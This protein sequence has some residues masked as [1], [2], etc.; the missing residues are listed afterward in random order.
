LPSA[1]LPAARDERRAGQT[2]PLKAVAVLFTHFS[3]AGS[4]D[5][6]GHITPFI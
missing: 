1:Y 6:V 4:I 5:N 3:D 2:L